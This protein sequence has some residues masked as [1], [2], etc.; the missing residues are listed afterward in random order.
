MLRQVIILRKVIHIVTA[1]LLL[2]L[3]FN[4]NTAA[5]DSIPSPASTRK[6]FQPLPLKATM[7]AAAFPGAGQI[8]NRKYWK[9]PFAY[10]GFGGLGYAVVFNTKNYNKYTKAYQ[11][12]TD[13]VPET[14]SYTDVIPPSIPPE[15]YDPVLHPDTYEPSTAS[16]VSDGLIRQVDYFRKYRDLSYIGIGVWYLITILDANVD[17]SL[18]DYDVN[19]NLNLT[20]SPIQVPKYNLTA[21]GVGV[22]MKINF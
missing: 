17:A 18:F 1:S 5:Q 13:K 2:I 16:W 8:Y 6:K 10:A 19:E 9:V 3:P 21:F 12:F 22:S 7:L 11:D 4:W 14:D 15:E 20:L